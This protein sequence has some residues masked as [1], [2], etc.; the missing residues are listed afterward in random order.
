MLEDSMWHPGSLSC[1][2]FGESPLIPFCLTGRSC[3]LPNFS[4]LFLVL[5]L[6]VL[7]FSFRWLACSFFVLLIA[8]LV[9]FF[10]VIPVIFWGD[11]LLFGI[12]LLYC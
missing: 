3:P 8:C 4:P 5:A 11:P 10:G 2:N 7:L 12:M 6:A 1:R 9:A